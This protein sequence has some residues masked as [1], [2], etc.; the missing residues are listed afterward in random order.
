[1]T[2]SVVASVTIALLFGGV[3]LLPASPALAKKKK[4]SSD[5]PAVQVNDEAAPAASG[6]TADQVGD[7]EKPKTILD[8]SQDAPKTD[9]LGHVHFGSPN[10]TGIGR[11]AVKASPE[12]KI[13]IFLEGRYFGTAPLTIYSVPK[14]DYIVEA[15]F[16]NGKQ[17][18][19]PVTVNENEETAF[20]LEGAQALKRDGGPGMFDAEMTPGR[21]TWTKVFLVTAGVGAIAAITFGILELKAESD[22]EKAVG[23]QQ[24]DDIASKGRN[25]ALLTNIGIVV[26]AV[27]LVGAGIAGYPL[28][29]RPSEKSKAAL[30]FTPAGGPGMAGAAA[31]LRF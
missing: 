29:L 3:V 1:M 26:T 22:Y 16:A 4:A 24:M 23:Q 8:T 21:L 13:K 31:T 30:I 7:T 5:E 18:S 15:V 2:R 19:R 25:Y 12:S 28:V 17:V 9:S 11:V 6:K 20:E 10:A 27:G 14:G